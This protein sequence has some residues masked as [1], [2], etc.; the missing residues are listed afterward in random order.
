MGVGIR[1]ELTFQITKQLTKV[2]I[3]GNQNRKKYIKNNLSVTLFY[4]LLKTQ[5]L[6]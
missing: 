1:I 6:T 3:D 2:N 4:P 5:D